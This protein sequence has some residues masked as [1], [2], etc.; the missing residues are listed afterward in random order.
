VKAD[1][2]EMFMLQRVPWKMR[3]EMVK[4]KQINILNGRN[5]VV[6]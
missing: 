3:L 1:K 6:N 5:I 2:C 4:E